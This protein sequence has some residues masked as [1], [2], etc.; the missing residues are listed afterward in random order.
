MKQKHLIGGLMILFGL[1][2]CYY[3]KS[4]D[5]LNSCPKTVQ[6]FILSVLSLIS[7]GFGIIKIIS[8]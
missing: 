5:M 7:I 1:G 4:N 2:I 3:L 8:R 6:E